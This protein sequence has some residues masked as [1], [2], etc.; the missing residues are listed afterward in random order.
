MTV[1][2]PF[3]FFFTVPSRI[4]KHSALIF[5]IVPLHESTFLCPS[6]PLG[7]Q[8]S[9]FTLFSYYFI[10]TALST[11]TIFIN[12]CILLKAADNSNSQKLMKNILPHIITGWRVGEEGWGLQNSYKICQNVPQGL[13][14]RTQY[15][16]GISSLITSYLCLLWFLSECLP[17]SFPATDRL[18]L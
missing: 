1:F 17:H 16:Q 7:S 4:M 11:L 5:C 8:N 14:P 15:F 10:H 12:T 3:L 18:S 13:E 9:I 6:L 2:L